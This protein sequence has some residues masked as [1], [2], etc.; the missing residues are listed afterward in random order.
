MSS[1]QTAFRTAL[2]A[3]SSLSSLISTSLLAARLSV[4]DALVR[5]TRSARTGLRAAVPGKVFPTIAVT[6]TVAAVLLAATTTTPAVAAHSVSLSHA[7][8]PLNIAAGTTTP[9]SVDTGSMDAVTNIVGAKASWQA[10]YTG[11]GIDVA[12][13]DTGVTPVPGL[14][15]G[16]V[17]NGPDLSFDSQSSSLTRLDGFGHGTHLAGIIAGHDTVK[18][19]RSTV[20][21]GPA[22]TGVAPGS[23]V[24]NLKVGAYDGSADVSQVIAAVDWA[25]QHAH[26]HGL[27]IRIINLSFGTDS[28]QPYT[29]DPL[30]FAVENAWRKGIVVVVAAGNDG[31]SRATLNDPAIDPYVLAVGADDPD[32]TLSPDNDL[33]PTFASRGTSARHADLVAPGMHIASLRDPGSVVDT[34]YPQA[35]VGDRLFRGSG[36]SQSAAVVS[37]CAALLLSKYPGLTPDQVKKQLMRTARPLA[38]TALHRGSG[39]IDVAR[40]EQLPPVSARQARQSAPQATGRGSLEA[41]RGT[42]HVVDGDTALTGEQDIFGSTWNGTHWAA[43]DTRGQAWT[44][45]DWNGDTWTGTGWVLARL[46]GVVH[47]LPSW[48]GVTWSAPTWTGGNWLGHSWTSMRWDGHSWT[49]GTWSG[50]SW[51]DHEWSGHSWTG[52]SWSYAGWN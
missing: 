2:S 28:T 34:D 49:G 26:D 45:G 11:Q 41:A 46:L 6:G 48:V 29:S 37:G 33:V 12:L 22:F 27:N 23:R 8:H 19:P 21:G 43:A 35:R 9:R 16:N 25:T 14:S 40:A 42:A 52:S 15:S 5:G 36:T 32:G 51:T 44:G 7:Q 39:L 31:T 30:A 50:H 10:G 38:E 20:K 17:V 4:G 3:L 18:A 13:I 24:I 1:P 47:R